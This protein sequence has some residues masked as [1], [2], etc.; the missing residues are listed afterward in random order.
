MTSN[1]LE[2]A[3]RIFIIALSSC[4][5]L[6]VSGYFIFCSTVVNPRFYEIV[7]SDKAVIASFGYAA[8]QISR[9]GPIKLSSQS[10]I[11][12]TI[13]V[14]DGFIRF[15]VQKDMSLSSI[16]IEEENISS[17][18]AVVLATTTDS[19]EI[20]QIN[21]IHP[22]VFTYLMPESEDIYSLLYLIQKGFSV[23]RFICP[24]LCIAILLL[25]L[26]SDKTAEN[27]R[28]VLF[29]AGFFIIGSVF[30][31]HLVKKTVI[32]SSSFKY[33]A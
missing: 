3:K 9:A 20:P 22:Y 26:F 1:R 23:A 21:R 27:A 31:F 33:N 14:I 15:V 2:T 24:G 10:L 4:M 6:F 11:N 7:F 13:T 16:S 8:E 29:V 18:P 19:P 32:N 5:L 12:N 28:T 30:L 17:I 25:L